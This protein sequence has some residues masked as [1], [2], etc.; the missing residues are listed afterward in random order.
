MH[1]FQL[2]N[3]RDWRRYLRDSLSVIRAFVEESDDGKSLERTVPQRRHLKLSEPIFS[4]DC[5]IKPGNDE[6]F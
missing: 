5:R 2:N 4:M 6:V 1:V 3:S